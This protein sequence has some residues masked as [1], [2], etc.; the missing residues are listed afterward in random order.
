[1]TGEYDTYISSFAS[2]LLSAHVE[3]F[4]ASR[5]QDFKVSISRTAQGGTRQGRSHGISLNS[6]KGT[7]SESDDESAKRYFTIFLF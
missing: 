6:I 7:G 3:I 5:I 2:V 4:S 1:M